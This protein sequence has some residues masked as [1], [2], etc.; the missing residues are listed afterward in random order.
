MKCKYLNKWRQ[1]AQNFLATPTHSNI[2]EKYRKIF[3]EQVIW[4]KQAKE[5]MYDILEKIKANL[6]LRE[7]HYKK[8]IAS[9]LFAWPS[10]VGKT[11]I[12]HIMQ[13][14]LNEFFNTNNEIIKINCSD[15]QWEQPFSLTRLIGASAWYIWSDKKPKFHPDNIGW[16]WRIILFDEIEKAWTPLKNLLL[17]ILDD[18]ELEVNYT[19][20]QYNGTYSIL[21]T[22]IKTN[23][24]E[25]NS[26]IKSY[27]QDKIIILTSNIW[28]WKLDEEVNWRKMWFAQEKKEIE[29]INNLA[30]NTILNELSN[31]FKLELQG[32]FNYIVPFSY[33]EKEE[34]NQLIEIFI[35][36]IINKLTK[37][38]WLFIIFSEEL[39][40]KILEE[41]YSNKNFRQYWVRYIEKY[42][43]IN[44]ITPIAKIINKWWYENNWLYIFLNNDKINFSLIPMKELTK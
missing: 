22:P 9:L 44:I 16:K 1:L 30:E 14:A 18:G 2:I 31:H 21:K 3:E 25:E 5:I 6:I 17:S 42:F 11:K 32:R 36:N 28:I 20:A 33:F 41:I 35:N 37:E 29:K 10:W 24:T 15:F 40:Q 7:E 4:Q 27:F 43:D 39:K 8:P 19:E 23:K 12:A 34:T 38:K 26:F 13:E